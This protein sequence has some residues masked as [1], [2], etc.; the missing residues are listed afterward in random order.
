MRLPLRSLLGWA[1]HPWQLHRGSELHYVGRG[2]REQG[3]RGE[4]WTA[5]WGMRDGANGSQKSKRGQGG[6]KIWGA[7]HL[8]AAFSD[9]AGKKKLNPIKDI[10]AWFFFLHLMHIFSLLKWKHPVLLNLG[11][12]TVLTDEQTQQG[13]EKKAGLLFHRVAKSSKLCFSALIYPISF[14][15]SMIL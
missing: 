12:G 10:I 7:A 6:G 9:S 13:A 1:A 11:R 4:A 15:L 8:E 5:I 2:A 14:F 3:K